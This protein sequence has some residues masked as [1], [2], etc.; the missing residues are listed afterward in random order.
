LILLLCKFGEGG[1]VGIEDV[2]RVVDTHAHL[3]DLED[4]EGVISRAREVGIKAIVAVGGN[5]E[6]S[7]TTLSWADEFGDFVYPAIGIHP[8]EWMQDNVPDTLDFIESNLDRC[9][10]VGEIGLDYWYR[11]AK[12]SGEIREK[13]REIY[14]DLLGMAESHSKPASVHSRGA[15]QDALELAREHGPERIVFHWFSGSIEVLRGVLDSGFLI[16]AT[17]AAEFSKHHRAALAE[18]PLEKVVIETDS[19]VR[20]H[21]KR[22]EPSDILL[23]LKSLA[24]IK[25]LPEEDVA[26]VTTLNAKRLFGF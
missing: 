3:S 18:A 22:T 4:Q 14:I 26:E 21:G 11:E 9:V 25:G 5:L 16:S 6:T 2:L 23:T 17:P 10:A 1:S 8:S 20:Y 24:E 13:Q 7:R 15:W 12:K 19:P